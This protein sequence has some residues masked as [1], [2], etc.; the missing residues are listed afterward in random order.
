MPL[1]FVNSVKQH[2]LSVHLKP[3]PTLQ[4]CTVLVYIMI[5]SKPGK[6]STQSSIRNINQCPECRCLIWVPPAP[7]PSAAGHTTHSKSGQNLEYSCGKPGLL[8]TCCAPC[9]QPRTGKRR[10]NPC[11]T[12]HWEKNHKPQKNRT[13]FTDK[14]NI[15]SNK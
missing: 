8:Q 11:E 13:I 12:Q 4:T 9:V 14:I 10:K 3:C 15:Y 7:L 5:T 1:Q 2:V 6:H